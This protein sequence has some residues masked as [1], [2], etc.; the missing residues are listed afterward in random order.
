MSSK[1][2]GHRNHPISFMSKEPI[3]GWILYTTRNQPTQ[4]LVYGTSSLGELL[5][6]AILQQL[7][8]DL[9]PWCPIIKQGETSC[10]F[11]R[12]W[13]QKTAFHFPRFAWLARQKQHFCHFC[14][15]DNLHEIGLSKGVRGKRCHT[16]FSKLQ[17]K[18][19]FVLKRYKDAKNNIS[20]S[21]SGKRRLFMKGK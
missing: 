14:L 17:R 3:T 13:L 8:K 21:N 10:T 18:G 5:V 15:C 6:T 1:N 4:V 11:C 20:S 2:K 9:Q 19:F 7:T 16:I 12:W